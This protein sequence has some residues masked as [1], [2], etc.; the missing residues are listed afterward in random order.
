MSA[1]HV[2][3]VCNRLSA[4][5]S[6]LEYDDVRSRRRDPETGQWRNVRAC[7]RCAIVL[8]RVARRGG[9]SNIHVRACKT[10]RKA[11]AAL[12]SALGI[13]TER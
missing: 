5:C 9:G 4:T 13:A 2:C 8:R 11:S 7:A 12:R 3:D 10:P 6:L 1:K